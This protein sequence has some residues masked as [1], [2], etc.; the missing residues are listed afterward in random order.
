MRGRSDPQ[1][2]M[3]H[4]YHIEERIPAGHPLRA[5]KASADQALRELAPVLPRHVQR[6]RPPLD[7]ARAALEERWL[8]GRRSQP[9]RGLELSDT[10]HRR[11]M[12][13]C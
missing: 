1:G 11:A 8:T 2:A 9:L 13:T 3:F 7:P 12:R 10:N 6:A 4:Y 5:I